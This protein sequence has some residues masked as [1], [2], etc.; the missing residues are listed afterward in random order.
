[1][2][3]LIE[4]VGPGGYFISEPESAKLCR[5]EVW[6]PVLSD[7]LPY[8]QWKDT[9]G[10]SMADRVRL[11]LVDILNH[12]NPP[13]IPQEALEKIHAILERE[14]ARVNEQGIEV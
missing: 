3:E 2:L 13:G 9:S 7:R 6:V 5:K 8:S 14:E 12:H 1:M 10:L 11:R 4:K